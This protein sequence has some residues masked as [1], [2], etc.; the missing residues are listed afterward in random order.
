[1]SSSPP[2]TRII[3]VRSS[4]AAPKHMMIAVGVV[5]TSASRPEAPADLD[6][7]L[8]QPVR[9]SAVAMERARERQHKPDR[10]VVHVPE[11]TRRSPT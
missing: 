4:W 5:N 8:L 7:G 2:S 11:N 1:M 9:G 3:R 6:E 10:V